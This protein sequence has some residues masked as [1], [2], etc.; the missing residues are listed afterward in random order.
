MLRQLLIIIFCFGLVSCGGGNDGEL[1][2]PIES[3]PPSQNPAPI[4][5]NQDA[6]ISNEPIE[7]PAPPLPLEP[8]INPDP[9][10]IELI[11]PA[12]N[13]T[14]IPSETTP[15]AINNPQLPVIESPSEPFDPY[16]HPI[17][18]N[19][20][21]VPPNPPVGMYSIYRSELTNS[22]TPWNEYIGSFNTLDEAEA[23]FRKEGEPL[24]YGEGFQYLIMTGKPNEF[25]GF[26]WPCVCIPR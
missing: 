9:I 19:R 5:S 21:I 3:L 8:I 2:T 6:P 15:P 11:P 10:P 22:T 12:I 7:I 18:F 14:P 17:A 1:S 25:Y 24:M 26:S 4:N 16:T 20:T 13:P 23:R